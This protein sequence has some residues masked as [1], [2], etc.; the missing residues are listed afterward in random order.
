MK[1]AEIK[2][3]YGQMQKSIKDEF[4]ALTTYAKN[5]LDSASKE[6]VMKVAES[7]KV[8]QA[9]LKKVQNERDQL[10][11]KLK[12]ETQKVESYKQRME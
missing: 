9:V 6:I 1:V 5:F 12:V 2:K 10:Q 4:G 3:V 7:R 8:D 11:D